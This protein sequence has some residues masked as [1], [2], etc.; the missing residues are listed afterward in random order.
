MIGCPTTFLPLNLKEKGSVGWTVQCVRNWLDSYTQ[1]ITANSSMSKKKPV[2]SGVPQGSVLAAAAV[3][4]DL[5]RFPKIKHKVLPLDPGKPHYQNRLGDGGQLCRKDLG[6]LLDET[7]AM[8]QQ[9]E[10][11]AQKAS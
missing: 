2:M 7:L 9:H 1:R 11:A 10:F 4:V 3:D 6:I 5:M 8:N